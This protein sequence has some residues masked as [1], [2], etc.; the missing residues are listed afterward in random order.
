MILIRCIVGLANVILVSVLIGWVES[1]P[2]HRPIHTY[3]WILAII[4]IV[5]TR[6]YL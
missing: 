5:I 6:L 3:A 2:K 1:S 4:I